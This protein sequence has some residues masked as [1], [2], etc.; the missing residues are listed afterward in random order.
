MPNYPW[1]KSSMTF[2]HLQNLHSLDAGG[3]SGILP[4]L[5]SN[6]ASQGIGNPSRMHRRQMSTR[7]CSR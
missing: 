3:V 4:A 5:A 1:K 7:T 2:F 6:A